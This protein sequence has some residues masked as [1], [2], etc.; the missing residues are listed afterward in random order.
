MSFTMQR[1][2]NSGSDFTP[3]DVRAWKFVIA[4]AVLLNGEYFKENEQ[5]DHEKN[6]RIYYAVSSS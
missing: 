5:L 4:N 1:Y 2:P 6:Q 3:L